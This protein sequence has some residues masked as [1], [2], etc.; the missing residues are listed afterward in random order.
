[1]ARN[2]KAAESPPHQI[3]RVYGSDRFNCWAVIHTE[4]DTASPPL[5]FLPSID[6][7]GLY[8]MW[9][10][11]RLMAHKPMHNQEQPQ[12]KTMSD[13]W[14]K[15][16]FQ[17]Q[18]NLPWKQIFYLIEM[19]TCWLFICQGHQVL[20]K[21]LLALR[22]WRGPLHLMNFRNLQVAKHSIIFPF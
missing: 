15:L 17:V 14:S 21:A 5:L 7:N 16:F 13:R 6:N 4:R 22:L 2:D 12:N 10:G 20:A 8:Q 11:W 1:M 3:W 18:H 9:G 19:F